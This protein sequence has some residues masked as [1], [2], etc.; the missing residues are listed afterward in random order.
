MGPSCH[1][2]VRV[3]GGTGP[4]VRSGVNTNFCPSSRVTRAVPS[5]WKTVQPLTACH[6]WLTRVSGSRKAGY[7]IWMRPGMTVLV[8]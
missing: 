8:E 2:T 1:Q 7:R 3:P 5:V 4:R 6:T